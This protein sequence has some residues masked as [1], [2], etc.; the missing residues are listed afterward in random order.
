M[1][2]KAPKP[3]FDV[4]DTAELEEEIEAII[5]TR[6][7][8]VPSVRKIIESGE[9]KDVARH[10]LKLLAAALADPAAG[11]PNRNPSVALD[12]AKAAVS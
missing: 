10:A 5:S 11:D 2:P 12:A 9:S 3:I 6:A 7:D 8:L 4:D 1:A